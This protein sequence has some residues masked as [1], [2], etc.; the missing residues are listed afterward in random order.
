[1]VQATNAIHPPPKSLEL[2]RSF[3][4]SSSEPLYQCLLVQLKVLSKIDEF[5]TNLDPTQI[6]EIQYNLQD[7]KDSINKIKYFG[8][9]SRTAFI[10]PKIY[11]GKTIYE[12]NIDGKSEYQ[13]FKT[14]HQMLIYACVCKQNDNF[15]RQITSF[16]NNV[17]TQT[18]HTGILDAVKVEVN[19]LTH[20]NQSREDAVY[21]LSQAISHHFMLGVADTD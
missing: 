19:P 2:A 5:E 21:T 18:Q 8:G 15:D 7:T 14:V 11:H 12:S 16:I 6:Y 1:M 4:S 9:T 3:S 20:L 17:L 13:I 10:G